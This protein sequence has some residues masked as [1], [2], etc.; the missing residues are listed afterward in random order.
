M[1]ALFIGGTGVISTPISKLLVERDWELSLLNR[2][3]HPD[4][5]PQG[6]RS[7][8]A[9]IADRE[10]TRQALS[11]QEWDV[12]A[13]FIAYRPDEVRRDIEWFNGRCGQYIFISSASA[14]HKPPADWLITEST[15]LHNPYWQ[16]SRDKAAC[17][18]VLF[19]AWRESGFPV[20]V[21]RPSHTYCDWSLPLCVHGGKGPWSTLARMLEGKPVPVIGDGTSLWTVTHSDDFAPAFAGLLGNIH[22]IGEAVHITSDEA[23]PWNQIYACIADA[24]GVRPNLLHVTSEALIARKPELSG[25]L[26]G[27]KAHSVVFDNSKLKRLV[28]GWRATIRFDQG[29]RRSVDYL[30]ANPEL[31]RPGPEWDAFIDSLSAG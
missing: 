7:I 19:A 8:T 17:E 21:V 9:D 4:R 13:Q 18:D 24:L 5:M 14:Y 12:V 31:Q 1:K 25:P 23:L 27:D 20:T 28:P 3:G 15:P 29:S 30:R 26:L 11:G 2:G 10:A 6:A 22:A 16:Y